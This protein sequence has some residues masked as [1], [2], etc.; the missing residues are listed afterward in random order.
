M[1]STPTPASRHRSLILDRALAKRTATIAFFRVTHD[2]YDLGA[3]RRAVDGTNLPLAQAELAEYLRRL[4]SGEPLDDFQP[5]LGLV[6]EKERVTADGDYNLSGERY[7]ERSPRTGNL[8]LA[9]IGDV[10][11]NQPS[12]KRIS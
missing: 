4:R 12:Q 2:G 11:L 6:V 8:P 9:A 10:W 1:C 3:Q 5:T 7:R